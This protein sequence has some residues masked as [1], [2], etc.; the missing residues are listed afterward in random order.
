MPGEDDEST[1]PPSMP[2]AQEFEDF[3]Q[4]DLPG[5][6]DEQ[7]QDSRPSRPPDPFDQQDPWKNL[8]GTTR[9]TTP[10]QRGQFAG[11]VTGAGM[12]TFDGGG[13]GHPRK[14]IHDVPPEWDGVDPQRNL[15]PYLK[16]LEA[17]LLTTATLP[18]QRGI[19]IMNYAKGDLRRLIDNLDLAQLT[20]RESGNET[21]KY[22]K[23]EYSE[24][25][26][27]KKPLRIEEAFYD[28][29]RCRKKN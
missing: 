27:C 22:I 23:A 3:G 29:E 21:L 13:G 28:P 14:V 1:M 4:S 12:G 15:E 16:L 24:Y 7:Q 11:A 19:V 18:E 9:Q 8:G 17:W 20:T 5:E 25:I 2:L 26:V 6:T 10:G